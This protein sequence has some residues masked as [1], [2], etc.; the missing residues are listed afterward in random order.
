MIFI[1]KK[2]K[3]LISVISIGIIGAGIYLIEGNNTNSEKS[4]ANSNNFSNVNLN[5]NDILNSIESKTEIKKVQFNTAEEMFE[6]ADKINSISGL[7]EAEEFIKDF[8]VCSENADI[9]LLTTYYHE[10]IRDIVINR[11]AYPF[12]DTSNTL[13]P[14]INNIKVVE[15]ENKDTYTATYTVDV[16]VR[17]TNEK[18]ATLKKKDTIN[19]YKEFEK[20]TISDYSTETTETIIN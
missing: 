6:Y 1:D 3:I 15:N 20:I 14:K 4:P 9:P 19:L 5:S 12:I 11:K 18:F 2:N 8:L 7:E 17:E 10:S 16:Y 13:Y